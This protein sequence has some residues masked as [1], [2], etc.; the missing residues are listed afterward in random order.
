[1]SGEDKIKQ[2][3]YDFTGDS[4]PDNAIASA[5]DYFNPASEKA[6]QSETLIRLLEFT[7]LS[8]FTD[9]DSFSINRLLG[10]KSEV[11]G[12]YYIDPSSFGS[13]GKSLIS[14]SDA[15]LE[16]SV[17]EAGPSTFDMPVPFYGI[18][19]EVHLQEVRIKGTITSG[20]S[21]GII[22]ENGSVTGKLYK[23]DALEAI[24]KAEEWCKT[25]DPKPPECSYFDVLKVVFNTVVKYDLD[26]GNSCSTC[27]EITGDK[28]KAAGLL[29]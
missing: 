15:S 27:F 21:G 8:N 10:V 18:I 16:N 14:F 28:A 23:Q 9:D 5:S 7:D 2:K 29:K 6:I 25:L 26:S 1:V 24:A 19:V 17:F 3:C 4:S 11:D 20:S 12:E 13:D 22:I